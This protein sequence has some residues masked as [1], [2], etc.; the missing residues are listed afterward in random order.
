MI[1]PSRRDTRSS[2]RSSAWPTVIAP[3]AKLAAKRR[4]EIF[5]IRRRASSRRSRSRCC[6][7]TPPSLPLRTPAPSRRDCRGTK[8]SETFSPAWQPMLNTIRPPKVRLAAT[9]SRALAVV[10]RAVPAGGRNWLW[11]AC[12]FSDT[13][14]GAEPPPSAPVRKRLRPGVRVL[15]SDSPRRVRRRRARRSPGAAPS[16][17]KSYPVV[18]AVVGCSRPGVGAAVNRSSCAAMSNGFSTSRPTESS[19]T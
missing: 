13:T 19:G 9:A 10:N 6:R 14:P 12:P 18:S 11:S 1:P 17:R 15:Q 2:P 8:K 16:L 7:R 4:F 5:R 3:P